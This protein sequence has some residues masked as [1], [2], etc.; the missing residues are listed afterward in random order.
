MVG[1]FLRWA[2][3]LTSTLYIGGK[4]LVKERMNKKGPCDIT[5]IVNGR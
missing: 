1:R 3:N 4:F 2:L 5:L